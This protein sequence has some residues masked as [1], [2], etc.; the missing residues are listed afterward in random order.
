MQKKILLEADEKE[1]SKKKKSRTTTFIMEDEY[2]ENTRVTGIHK[3]RRL[4]S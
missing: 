1:L 2:V 3:K 4:K